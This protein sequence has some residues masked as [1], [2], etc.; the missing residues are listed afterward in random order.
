MLHF[1]LVSLLALALAA[2]FGVGE[3]AKRCLKVDRFLE[4]NASYEVPQLDALVSQTPDIAFRYAM[5][6]LFPL[7]LFV[8]ILIGGACAIASLVWVRY[9]GAPWDWAWLVLLVPIFYVAVD[10]AEDSMLALMLTKSVGIDQT[11]VGFTKALTVMKL[12]SVGA[13]GFQ[14]VALGLAAGAWGIWKAIS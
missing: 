14:T 2:F 13:A 6:V 1:W 10:L 3:F 8:M 4:H 11:V 12:A 5:P 9:L 7:D